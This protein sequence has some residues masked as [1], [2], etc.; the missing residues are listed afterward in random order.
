MPY[1]FRRAS[2]YGA[3]IYLIYSFGSR[4]LLLK[5]HRRGI[6]LT[7]LDSY[8]DAINEFRLSYEFLSR[9]SWLDKYRFITM[10]A[11]SAVSYREMAL[12]N[13]GYSYAR[14][15]EMSAALQSY[16]RALQ[17]FPESEIAKA[18]LNILNRRERNSL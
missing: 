3:A 18:A 17:E 11:S 15:N 10:L 5:N 1:D 12:C 9:Y 6:Y 7:K 4:A 8:Q 14:L 2:V 16:R 13:I